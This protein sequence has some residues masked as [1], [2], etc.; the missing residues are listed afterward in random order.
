MQLHFLLRKTWT[1]E[2]HFLITKCISDKV[3]Y[4]Q[5][6]ANSN[7][8]CRSIFGSGHAGK[9]L[10]FESA[11]CDFEYF[12]LEW[13]F[14]VLCYWMKK[15]D[16]VDASSFRLVETPLYYNEQWINKYTVAYIMENVTICWLASRIT[17]YF[18]VDL[19]TA[20]SVKYARPR[21]HSIQFNLKTIGHILHLLHPVGKLRKYWLAASRL[22]IV[23]CLGFLSGI[24]P[25]S[26]EN[27][28]TNWICWPLGYPIRFST[29]CVHLRVMA[30]LS[31]H[32]FGVVIYYWSHVL[33]LFRL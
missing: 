12:H 8:C 10:T 18:K 5:A 21:Q 14:F 27:Q 16:Y 30:T 2:I 20:I 28:N 31:V 3:I 24:K 33:W 19:V 23:P 13:W 26:A 11:G 4:S 22:F 32:A 9:V 15:E 29:T 7:W 1:G 25:R 17:W 6:S